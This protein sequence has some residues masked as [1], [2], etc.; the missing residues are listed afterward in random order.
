MKSW[1]VRRVG[2]STP[3]MGVWK[4]SRCRSQ[5]PWPMAHPRRRANIRV[6]DISGRMG[7]G[8]ELLA[9]LPQPE[10][11]RGASGRIWVQCIWYNWRSRGAP[12]RNPQRT[13]KNGVAGKLEPFTTRTYSFHAHLYDLREGNGGFLES[14]TVLAHSRELP[15]S[16]DLSISSPHCLRSRLSTAV[17]TS[18]NLLFSLRPPSFMHGIRP[19]S[20][21]S[22]GS[23]VLNGPS[24]PCYW[25][26]GTCLLPVLPHDDSLVSLIS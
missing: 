23:A 15:C 8:R 21:S 6:C 25:L 24:P 16:L 11:H 20:C 1:N 2:C 7:G 13:V 3:P 18:L 5:A 10:A 26:I 17:V 4:A 19:R 9:G 14:P 12:R 22:R